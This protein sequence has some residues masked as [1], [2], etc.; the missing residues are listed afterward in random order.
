MQPTGRPAWRGY[1]DPRLVND[2]IAEQAMQTADQTRITYVDDQGVPTSVWTLTDL[3]ERA[4]RHAGA[5][6]A[7]GVT[8]GDRVLIMVGNHPEFLPAFLGTLYLGAV[9]VP[10][11][12]AMRGRSLGGL[13]RDADPSYALV[14]SAHQSELFEQSDESVRTT[15]RGVWTLGPSD[16]AMTAEWALPLGEDPDRA[17][18]YEGS[19]IRP[20]EELAALMYTSGTTGGPKGVMVSHQMLYAWAQATQ[21]NI[22]YNPDDVAFAC[23]PLFHSN[24]LVC[25]FLASVLGGADVVIAPRFSASNY[26]T[27]IHR[28]GATATN[29]L[30]TMGQ[31]LWQREVS[32]LEQQHQ[33][34]RMMLVPS[35]PASR[36]EAFERRFNVKLTELYGLT[37]S[38]IP[39]AVPHEQR[40]P[41]SCG[42]PTPGW[43]CAIVDDQDVPV[44]DGD[45]GELVL[46][47][48]VPFIG[49]SGYWNR[50]EDTVAAW[51]NLWFHTGDFVR[52]DSDGWFYFVGRKKQMIRR[53]GE[54]ISPSE[55]ETAV[56]S[57]PHVMDAAAYAVADDVMGEEVMVAVVPEKDK[58]ID[59]RSLI[60]RCAAD[61]PA[62]AVPRYIRF[63]DE[64][65]KTSTEKT[66]V[67]ALQAQGVTDDSIDMGTRKSAT[68]F[69]IDGGR[70][71]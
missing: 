24:A 41:G 16:D 27:Q 4:R 1:A 55:V 35:P 33:L 42:V 10:V 17:S 7:S 3:H 40:R 25:T 51:R 12:T 38:G 43:R 13:L 46:R 70:A 19:M 61:L 20:P 15:L 9:A 22:G 31:I 49:M 45:V 67:S 63:V 11:N 50:P 8:A 34:S 71:T 18:P 47:P 14:D 30:G 37:D 44:N 59:P 32:A 23:L 68:D 69:R 62:F 5:M 60:R 2:L 54:N 58:T 52:R 29:L 21:F 65:P 39:L 28:S 64:L 57:D 56:L 6:L 53:G 66:T 48:Q 26:W 36:Y